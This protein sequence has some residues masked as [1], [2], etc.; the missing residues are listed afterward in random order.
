MFWSQSGVSVV[1]DDKFM[2]MVAEDKLIHVY[3]ASVSSL[4]GKSV[5]LSTGQTLP[6]DAAVFAT[7]WTRTQ[8]A[9]FDASLYEELGLPLLLQQQSADSAKHWD[10]LDSESDA[11]VR[12]MFPMLNS[13]PPEVVEY[14][15]K[16]EHPVST[17]PFR[18][19]RD[20]VPPTLAAKGDRSLIVL[21]TLL[22]TN[23][24]TYAEVSSLWAIAYL[25]NLPF[26]PNAAKT[27]TDLQAMED[28][29]SML[30]AWGQLKFPGLADAYPE[31]SGEIQNFTDVLMED[32]GLRADRKRLGAE[33]DGKRGLFGLRAWYNEWFT[34]YRGLDYKGLVAEYMASLSKA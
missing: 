19:Y 33:K 13:P 21:G 30:N 27:M 18:L 1:H 10:N 6:C 32:L 34:P 14:F 26:V 31:G 25:E 3:R 22:N 2:K 8:P 29:I 9:I 28:S 15:R 23:V 11:K 17:T 5:H 12:K 4:T 7:G 16:H 20:I 24:P